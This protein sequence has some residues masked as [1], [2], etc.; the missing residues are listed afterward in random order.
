MWNR[1]FCQLMLLLNIW[2]VIIFIYRLKMNDSFGVSM[3]AFAIQNVIAFSIYT[4]KEIF[5]KKINK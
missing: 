1:I 3:L 5:K 2:L 4:A